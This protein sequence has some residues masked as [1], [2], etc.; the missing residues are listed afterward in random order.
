MEVLVE[1]LLEFLMS[2]QYAPYAVIVVGVFYIASH[3]V[4]L[5]PEKIYS[6]I[7]TWALKLINAVAANY[8]NTRNAK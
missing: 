5:L 2:S 4:A 6:K 8:K 3:V 1:Q 7:P